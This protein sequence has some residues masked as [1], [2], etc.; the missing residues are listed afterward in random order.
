MNFQNVSNMASLDSWFYECRK[1]IY[2]T[3]AAVFRLKMYLLSC[4]YCVLQV[5]LLWLLSLNL[6][7]VV[8]YHARLSSDALTFKP[9]IGCLHLWKCPLHLHFNVL[10]CTGSLSLWPCSGTHTCP[11]LVHST[12]TSPCTGNAHWQIGSKGRMEPSGRKAVTALRRQTGGAGVPPSGALY[13]GTLLLWSLS[14]PS[15]PFYYHTSSLQTGNGCRSTTI[16]LIRVDWGKTKY[17]ISSYILS[18]V[19]VENGTKFLSPRQKNFERQ[20]KYSLRLR[21]HTPLSMQIS[22]DFQN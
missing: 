2:N 11:A 19:Q 5:N 13:N 8:E 1:P 17:F 21:H 10:Q 6:I 22:I 7:I 20:I 4:W 12:A 9:Y 3:G 14:C 15:R 16:Q 18:A